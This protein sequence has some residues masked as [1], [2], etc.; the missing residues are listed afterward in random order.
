[1]QAF[2]KLYDSTYEFTYTGITYDVLCQGQFKIQ[3]D[4]IV[5]AASASSLKSDTSTFSIDSL[6]APLNTQFTIQKVKFCEPV[7]IGIINKDTI[8]FHSCIFIKK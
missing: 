8:Y 7:E 5:F 2:F 1:M 3:S 6:G 4:T